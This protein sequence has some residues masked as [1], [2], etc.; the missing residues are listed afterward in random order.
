MGSGKLFFLGYTYRKKDVLGYVDLLYTFDSF[1]QNLD[2]YWYFN[3]V[4]SLFTI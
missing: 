3:G 1:M 4:N 2:V